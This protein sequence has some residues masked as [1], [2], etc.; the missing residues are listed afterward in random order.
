MAALRYGT[1]RLGGSAIQRPRQIYTAAMEDSQGGRPVWPTSS[2]R[3]GSPSS[4][5]AANSSTED[6]CAKPA[7]ELLDPETKEFLARA[8]LKKINEKKEEL[9]REIAKMDRQFPSRCSREDTQL[10]M[11]LS[12]YVEP[13]PN[14]CQWAVFPKSKKM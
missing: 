8:Q 14:D 1:R 11:I 2:R 4:S 9:F 7:A 3:S 5:G 6:A 13:K 10:L 12:E